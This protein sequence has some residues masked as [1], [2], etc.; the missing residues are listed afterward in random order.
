MKKILVLFTM[1]MVIQFACKKTVIIVPTACLQVDKTVAKKNDTLRFT[2]CSQGAET[3]YFT[4]FKVRPD[5]GKIQ[6]GYSFN[7]QRKCEVVLND[8]GSFTAQI[9]AINDRA[10]IQTFEIPIIVKP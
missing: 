9:Q 8:T 4:V 1:V 2:D 7:E 6:I 10:P 5:P 3:V